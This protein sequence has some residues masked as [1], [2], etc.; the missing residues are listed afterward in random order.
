M[1]F[2]QKGPEAIATRNT[3]VIRDN[4]LTD[5]LRSKCEQMIGECKRLSL[6]ERRNRYGDL[7]RL[8]A[9][10]LKNK[11]KNFEEMKKR[12]TERGLF[13]SIDFTIV[14]NDETEMFIREIFQIL[15]NKLDQGD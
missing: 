1:D 3:I 9:E 10:L 6:K 14:P 5:E 8:L 13:E 11:N 15:T 4:E 12:L 2:E 7:N